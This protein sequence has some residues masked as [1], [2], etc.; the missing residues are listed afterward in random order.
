MVFGHEGCK[1]P[2]GSQCQHFPNGRK[3]RFRL[4]GGQTTEV[5]WMD[6]QGIRYKVYCNAFAAN[7]PAVGWRNM[8]AGF[9]FLDVNSSNG[10]IEFLPEGPITSDECST[11]CTM[12]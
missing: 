2:G 12:L 3:E 11:M 5:K 10:P 6:Q 7:Q 9:D 1:N 4:G 8:F